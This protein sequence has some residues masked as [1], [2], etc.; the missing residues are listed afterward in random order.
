MNYYKKAVPKVPLVLPNS[1]GI[2]FENIDHEW[3]IFATDNPDLIRM[4]ETCIVS[5]QGGVEQITAE[6]YL[7]FK[8]KKN[9]SL[10]PRW[11]EE[12][13]PGKRKP[14]SSVS[15]QAGAAPAATDSGPIEPIQ[16]PE[17]A[18]NF[19]PTATK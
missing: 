7:A 4:I 6:E 3:G 19:R 9:G 17:E 14:M 5:H 10:K 11:R 16:T 8:S 13:W 12:F 1:G 15:R 18:L 2:R